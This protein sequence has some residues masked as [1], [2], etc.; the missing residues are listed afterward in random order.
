MLNM[1]Y[2][3]TNRYNIDDK[4]L[5]KFL[6]KIENN[7]ISVEID[8]TNYLTDGYTLYLKEEFQKMLNQEIYPFPEHVS[9]KNKRDYKVSNLKETKLEIIDLLKRPKPKNPIFD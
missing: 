4:E 7:T 5:S 8:D 9:L 6:K 1:V 3:K 2:T